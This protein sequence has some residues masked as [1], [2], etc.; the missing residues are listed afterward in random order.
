MKRNKVDYELTIRQFDNLLPE[1]MK[2]PW[3]HALNV[4]Q[5]KVTVVKDKCDYA[6]NIIECFHANNEKYIFA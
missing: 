6:L 2:G 5:D 3:K 1:E 4:C